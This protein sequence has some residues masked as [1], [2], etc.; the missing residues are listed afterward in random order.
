MQLQ[1]LTLLLLSATTVG[2]Q[3]LPSEMYYSPDGKILY[4]GGKPAEGF[5]AK[6]SI[7]SIYLTFGQP[8]WWDLL[9]DN[10]ESETL[11]PATMTVNGVVYDSV[12]VRFRGNTSYTMTGNSPKKSFAVETDFI[13]EDQEFMGY[14]NLKFNNAHQ[15][16]TF[17]REVLYCRMAAR[18]TP[19]AKS[20][21]VELYLNGEY[22]GIYPNIQGVDKTFLEGY[23]LSNDGARFRATKEDNGGFGGGWGDGTAGMN[24][25][26]P[27]T[28]D[29]Q[30]YYELKSSD[31]ENS[32]QKL[33]DA[34]YS[35]S[36]ATQANMADVQNV[37]DVDKALWFLAVENIFTDDD[38]YVMKGKMDYYVY[39]EPETGRTTPLEYDGNSSF[40]TNQA[41]SNSWGPFKNV[42]NVNYPLL[43]KLL[44]IPEC[45]QRYLAHYR[46]IL[47]ETFTTA[48][49]NALIDSLD[50]QIRTLVNNDTKKLYP[51]NQYT[52]GISSLKTFV[53]N[54]R[55][56]LI[57]NAEVAQVAP[58][59]ASAVYYNSAL[60]ESTPPASEESAIVR[61]T[62]TSTNGITKVNLYYSTGLTGNFTA[63]EMF[64]DGLH[65]DI[66]ASDGI[67]G[68]E[69]PGFNTGT[70]VRY[71]IEAIAGNAAL[72]VSYLPTGAEHDVFVYTVQEIA[73]P[74]GV[75]IN[76]ILASNNSGATDENGDHEDWV[77]LF[78][79][80]DFEVD[81]SG[82][83]MTDDGSE[84]DKWQIPQGTIIPAQGYLIIWADEDLDDGPL[85]AD[86]KLSA[87]GEAVV[88]S[89]QSLSIVDEVEFG[90]QTTD[91]GYARFP[92]GTGDFRI[93]QA[94]FNTNNN[95]QIVVS[96]IAVNELLASNVDGVT[97]EAGDHED[98]I[99]LFNKNDF[100]VDLSGLFISDDTSNLAKWAIPQGTTIAAK[101]YLIVW[102]DEEG[103]EGPLHT[104]F[105]LSATGESVILSN[106]LENILDRIDFGPQ[107]ADLAY[108]RIPNGTGNF[109]IQA[110][111]F[112]ANNET[113]SA[114]AP[115]LSNDF[116]LYPNP[117]DQNLHVQ[118]TGLASETE[119]YIVDQFGRT[120]LRGIITAENTVVSVQDLPS[121]LYYFKAD[122]FVPGKLL[123]L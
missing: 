76:E 8:D 97:D 42:N 30:K 60:E 65:N 47:Q 95:I 9:A 48:N 112:A 20:N 15:D 26:G 49:A 29:Y 34:C 114:L 63:T 54:R 103:V 85:H 92:N 107:T 2:A 101:G 21:Y 87:G 22:W 66:E 43:N 4:T 57:N 13:D 56:F 44:N 113:I 27:D 84:P 78:N 58:A 83:Y 94:T 3:S 69:I 116:L 50:A 99:E 67:F 79:T 41:T 64:D 122:G 106:G 72:S 23:F 51:F 86:F 46:T 1:W 91:L 73:N 6:D 71:Y 7:R 36:T 77:E 39:Y 53:Q 74:N 118:L 123:K 37:I 111:T 59:I 121:G 18:H 45:R 104:S 89:N 10:Y 55:N 11:L 108:A 33:V 19:I 62:V 81:L 117:V 70:I 90:A 105:K 28:A 96:G 102:A 52:S 40:L 75:V 35:L 120:A 98:W 17:M 100:D 31:T 25:L 5:Y 61:T 68:G 82:Y 109:V 12:G 24:Y 88:L 32:W 119:Y 38:S 93:Q 14:K 115:E 110:P 16:A 80:N